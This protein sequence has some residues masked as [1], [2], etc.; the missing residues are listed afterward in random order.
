MPGVVREETLLLFLSQIRSHNKLF[1]ASKAMGIG[2]RSASKYAA[3]LASRGLITHRNHKYS[4]WV[5]TPAGH[6]LLAKEPLI[7]NSQ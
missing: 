3:I 2:R 6:E 1:S 7:A 5:L 4:G